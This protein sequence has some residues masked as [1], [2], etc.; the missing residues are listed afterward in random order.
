MKV[1]IW[2]SNCTVLRISSNAINE[3]D[4]GASNIHDC[5][6]VNTR[7][8]S[9]RMTS[10]LI[11]FFRIDNFEVTHCDFFPRQV[12]L[13]Q[14]FSPGPVRATREAKDIDWHVRANVL[15]DFS[16]GSNLQSQSTFETP[17]FSPQQN[18]HRR[19]PT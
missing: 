13:V 6:L 15:L 5:H 7:C 4:V 10:N 8:E 9:L 19:G 17:H 1:N 12:D 18:V 16:L 3:L 14:S 2:N 11:R